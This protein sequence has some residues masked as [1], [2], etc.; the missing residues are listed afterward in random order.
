M[1]VGVGVIGYAVGV[2]VGG[3]SSGMYVGVGVG[4]KHV[5]L[6]IEPMAALYQLP[7]VQSVGGDSDTVSD[8]YIVTL[9]LSKDAYRLSGTFTKSSC[10]VR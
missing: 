4:L 6:G 2:G 7:C 10:S 8:V 5:M 1:A 3:G 9:W